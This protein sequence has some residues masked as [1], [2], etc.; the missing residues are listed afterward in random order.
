MSQKSASGNGG[1]QSVAEWIT[2]SV[3]VAVVLAVVGVI[4]YD[5]F[6]SAALRMPVIEVETVMGEV[7]EVDGAY[8]LPIEVTNRSEHTAE[9]VRVQVSLMPD[10]GERETSQF[11]I[12]FLAGGDTEHEVV[13]F[14][15]DPSTADLSSDVQSFRRP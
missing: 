1:G 4:G 15:E 5:Y 14:D 11:T 10:Q 9:D 13:V 6:A 8:Y 2:L 12:A 7:Q 3:S